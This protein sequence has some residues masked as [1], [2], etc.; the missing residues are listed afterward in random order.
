METKCYYL[1]PSFIV[2]VIL[3]TLCKCIS[4]NDEAVKV[5]SISCCCYLAISSPCARTSEHKS[6][7]LPLEQPANYSIK[8]TMEG[9]RGL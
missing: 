3:D 8:K 4:V 5:A 6:C 1:I 2:K 9:S 7:K